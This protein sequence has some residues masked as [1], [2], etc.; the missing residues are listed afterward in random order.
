MRFSKPLSISLGMLSLVFTATSHA[1]TYIS[2]ID[3]L[4]TGTAVLNTKDNRPGLPATGSHGDVL[5]TYSAI[6]DTQSFTSVVNYDPAKEKVVYS[7]WVYT[8]SN[9]NFVNWVNTSDQFYTYDHGWSPSG[10][11]VETKLVYN[12]YIQTRTATVVPIPELDEYMLMLIGST[13]LT[14]KLKT[15]SAKTTAA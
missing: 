8:P 11:A 12:S 4:L 9:N 13:L 5:T 2:Q 10:A 14:Y 3:H 1:D 6:T 7:N 15:K